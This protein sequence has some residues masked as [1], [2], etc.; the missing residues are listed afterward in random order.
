VLKIEEFHEIRRF[1]KIKII[2][3]L[4]LLLTL[5]LVGCGLET[6]TLDVEAYGN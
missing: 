6:K 4:T 1:L 2:V 3:T 5:T